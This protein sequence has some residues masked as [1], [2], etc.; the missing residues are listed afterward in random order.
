MIALREMTTLL[1]LTSE[2]AIELPPAVALLALIVRPSSVSELAP[3]PITAVAGPLTT[4]TLAVMS[5]NQLA[6]LNPP[7]T[8]IWVRSV[9]PC[10]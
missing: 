4:V 6:A 1:L 7:Y 2:I 8:L 3:L 5:R 10:A 9:R